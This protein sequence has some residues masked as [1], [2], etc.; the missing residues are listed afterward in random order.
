MII[1]ASC[2]DALL[3]YSLKTVR[4]KGAVEEEAAEIERTHDSLLEERLENER[5]WLKELER[6]VVVVVVVFRIQR[7][8]CQPEKNYFTRW[9]ITLVV[10]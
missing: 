4:V 10:C 3:A 5:E 7:I 6:H 2:A 9:P 8:G 1:S